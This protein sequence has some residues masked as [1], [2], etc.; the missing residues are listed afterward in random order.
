MVRAIKYVLENPKQYGKPDVII[1][2]TD[3]GTGWPEQ[4]ELP[5][6]CKLVIALTQD[7]RT[8]S[9]AQTIKIP[10]IG[11]ITEEDDEV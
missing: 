7:E 2:C 1:C 5:R 10:D 3:G 4:E 11:K 6:R 8:P 9:W